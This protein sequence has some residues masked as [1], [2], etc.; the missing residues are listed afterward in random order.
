M[1]SKDFLTKQVPLLNIEDSGS[2]ALSQM[3]DYKLKHLPVVHEKHYKYLLSEKDVFLMGNIEDSIE[4]ISIYAPFVRENTSLLDVLRIMSKNLLSVLPVVDSLG[5]YIGAITLNILVEKMAE[6]TQTASHGA[7]IA[8][9]MNSQD[10]D[11]SHIVHLIE[12]N[13]AKILTLLSYPVEIT[14]KLI[15][16]LKI[17][18]EDASSVL[19]SLE[20]FNYTVLYYAQ[21]KILE[22]DTMRQRLGELM[23]YLE[24]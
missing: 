5:T 22:D 13:N 19:R 14:S 21:R 23:F 9:E 3:E 18:L 24:M 1:L 15:V 12:S 17:D 4:N 20:R 11:L 16:L 8:L 7:L 2:F 10:Y 6:G